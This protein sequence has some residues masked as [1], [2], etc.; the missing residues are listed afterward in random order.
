MA[1]EDVLDGEQQ[2]GLGY[3]LTSKSAPQQMG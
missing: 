3:I 1:F 2:V